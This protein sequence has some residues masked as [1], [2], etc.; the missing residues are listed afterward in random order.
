MLDQRYKS[1]TDAA[2]KVRSFRN[3]EIMIF[4]AVFAAG[5][6]LCA[7]QSNAE[8]QVRRL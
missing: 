6:L 2:S 5:L 7:L 8:L 4:K 3:Q 1:S